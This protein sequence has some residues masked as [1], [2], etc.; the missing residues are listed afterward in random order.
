M[1]SITI[2]SLMMFKNPHANE[3]L[4]AEIGVGWPAGAG[5]WLESLYVKSVEISSI[6]VVVSSSEV[7]V[8]LF[9][10]EILGSERA[11]CSLLSTKISVCSKK[12][13]VYIYIYTTGPNHG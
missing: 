7:L 6:S 11:S 2:L 3:G 5:S 12:K 1:V 8:L 9:V 4:I 10:F 13:S